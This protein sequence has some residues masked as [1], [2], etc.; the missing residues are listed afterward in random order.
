MEKKHE[1]SNNEVL[2]K[3]AYDK[4]TRIGYKGKKKYWYGYKKYVSVDM[5][6]RLI[7]KSAITTANESDA[8]GL[9][10]VCP[11]QGAVI[12]DRGCYTDPA[13]KVIKKKVA[14]TRL[15]RMII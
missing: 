4:E 11:N 8:Q 5:K 14:T 12:G 1:K 3:V 10:R 15:L 13:I 7:N 6:N 2:L 9:E